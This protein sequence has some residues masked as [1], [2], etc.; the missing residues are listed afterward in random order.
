MARFWV[1]LVLYV[2]RKGGFHG[3]VDLYNID[4]GV[5]NIMYNVPLSKSLNSSAPLYFLPQQHLN[6]FLCKIFERIKRM[7]GV[8]NSAQIATG[9]CLHWI[10]CEGCLASQCL[11]TLC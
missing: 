5:S 11:T 2:T 6:S 7:M 4:A 8:D 1:Q 3:R 9:G 10:W